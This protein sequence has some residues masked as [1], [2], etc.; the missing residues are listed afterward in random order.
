MPAHLRPALKQGDDVTLP[1]A[2]PELL[3]QHD[4]AVVDHAAIFPEPWHEE[5]PLR[6]IVPQVLEESAHLMPSLLPLRSLTAEQEPLLYENHEAAQQGRRGDLLSCFFVLAQKEADPDALLQ[7]LTDHLLL[8]SPQGYA[9]LRYYDP[10]VFIHLRRLLEPGQMRALFGPFQTWTFRFQEEWIRLS[11]PE[12]PEAP[13]APADE[14]PWEFSEAQRQ[15]LDRVGYI[16]TALAD[17]NK[18]LARPWHGL[19]EYDQL[20]EQ[21][22]RAI[23]RAQQDYQLKHSQDLSAFVRHT[24]RYGENF[25][26][27][28]LIQELM[29]ELPNEHAGYADI[30]YQLEESDWAAIAAE[31]PHLNLS[32][33]NLSGSQ[34]HD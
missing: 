7:H 20:A 10:R 11:A 24:L 8:H 29:R 18:K 4:Y 30:S 3:A 28:P 9:L 2:Y 21:A 34:Q 27:H 15:R 1:P 17:W 13:E 12:A 31:T 16:N 33:D 19:A 14:G 32:Q 25:H 5:L 22:D 23:V 6:R 26:L